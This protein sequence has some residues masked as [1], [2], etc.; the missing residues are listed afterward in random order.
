MKPTDKV[1]HPRDNI[2][3]NYQKIIYTI[4]NFTKSKIV[5]MYILPLFLFT[6]RIR[7]IINQT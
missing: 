4:A 7:F 6:Y 5:M 1:M 3:W 2:I